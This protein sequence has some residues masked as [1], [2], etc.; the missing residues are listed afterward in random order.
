[1]FRL[2]PALR[3]AVEWWKDVRDKCPA[4]STPEERPAP[5]MSGIG[6]GEFDQVG[7]DFVDLFVRLGNLTPDERVLDIGCGLGRMVEPLREYLSQEG[8]YE[9]FDVVREIIRWN[10]RNI[11]TFDPRFQ[12]R[13]VS[14]FNGSYNPNGRVWPERF[15]FPYRRREFDFV[16]AISVFT[17]LL[18][19]AATRYVQQAARVLRP[20][21]RLFATFFLLDEVALQHIGL[22]VS[23]QRFPHPKGHAWSAS[24]ESP[25]EAVAFRAEWACELLERHGLRVR[26]P[27]HYG[28]WSGR[29]GGLVYQDLVIADKR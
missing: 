28:S 16:F 24:L 11:S 4:P 27:I 26:Q 17:H 5:Y 6:Y 2:R 25:E 3:D 15:R 7:R 22:G 8:S 21:G 29:P 9:G 19:R 12:F 14:V 18:D 23:G 10:R 13:F 20:G 1:M